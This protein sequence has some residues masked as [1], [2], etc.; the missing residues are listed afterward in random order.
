MGLGLDG[1]GGDA[2]GF[3]EAVEGSLGVL[4]G[5]EVGWFAG[6]VEPGGESPGQVVGSGG[7]GEFRAAQFSLSGVAK[8]VSARTF[9][10]DNLPLANASTDAW[11]DAQRTTNAD[12][13]AGGAGL[14]VGDGGEPV[15]GG[16]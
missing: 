9:A 6:P 3:D 14:D 15:S 7:Q 12:P 1:E 11:S 10:Y 4:V 16:G 5:F 13:F 2:V 8:R